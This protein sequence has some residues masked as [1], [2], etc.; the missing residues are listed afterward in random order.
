M[1]VLE[2]DLIHPRGEPVGVWEGEKQ[3]KRGETAARLVA[4][5]YRRR[6][7]VGRGVDPA[8]SRPRHPRR[9]LKTAKRAFWGA[10][11]GKNREKRRKTGRKGGFGPQM[12]ANSRKLATPRAWWAFSSPA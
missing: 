5:G 9:G 7:I 4:P 11:R 12:D 3:I 6:K 2:A 10:W 8:G 1:L